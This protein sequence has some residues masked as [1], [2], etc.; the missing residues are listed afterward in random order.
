MRPDTFD[1]Q[2]NQCMMELRCLDAILVACDAR[3]DHDLL[4]DLAAR[5]VE[6]TLALAPFGVIVPL[7]EAV[8]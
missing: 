4:R 3:R 6:L 5:R 1:G 7:M 8:G 2:M